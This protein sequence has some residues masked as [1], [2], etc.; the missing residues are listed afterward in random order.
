MEKDFTIWSYFVDRWEKANELGFGKAQVIYDSAI[1]I[2]DVR[3]GRK[4]LDWTNVV[5]WMALVAFKL[6]VGVRFLLVCRYIHMIQLT[7]L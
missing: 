1:V 3:N 4:H 2:G 5:S 7:G 6:V